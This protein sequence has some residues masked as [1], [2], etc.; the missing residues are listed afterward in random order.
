MVFLW[1]AGRM[2]TTRPAQRTVVDVVNFGTILHSSVSSGYL[3][4]LLHL[5]YVPESPVPSDN[6]SL[7][8]SH[9]EQK[10]HDIT[11]ELTFNSII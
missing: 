2:I 5:L 8:S 11:T 10:T 9:Y 4:L 1:H 6:L 7:L 3:N